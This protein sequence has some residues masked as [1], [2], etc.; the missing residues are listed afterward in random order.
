MR[1]ASSLAALRAAPNTVIQV[2]RRKMRYASSLAALRAAPNSSSPSLCEGVMTLFGE[3]RCLES[4]RS[5]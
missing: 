3:P 1:Y 2:M 4:G 5:T